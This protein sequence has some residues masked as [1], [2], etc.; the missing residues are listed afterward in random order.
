MTVLFTVDEM[1]RLERLAAFYALPKGVAVHDIVC[2]AMRDA[3][4][5]VDDKDLALAETRAEGWRER[6][7]L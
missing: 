4:D 1:S 2:R 5:A 6:M 7:G 3:L